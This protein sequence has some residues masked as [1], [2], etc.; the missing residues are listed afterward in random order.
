MSAQS[1]RL[2]LGFSWVGHSLM[3]IVSGLY[4][5]VVLAL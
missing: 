1:A 2:S 3:H 5:T 4:L